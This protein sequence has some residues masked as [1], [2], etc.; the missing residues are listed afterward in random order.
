MNEEEPKDWEIGLLNTYLK[1]IGVK[2]D[3]AYANQLYD[4]ELV[5]WYPHTKK[6]KDYWGREIID[7]HTNLKAAE[8]IIYNG[9]LSDLEE[10]VKLKKQ[11]NTFLAVPDDASNKT[12]EGFIKELI[13]SGFRKEIDTLTFYEELKTGPLFWRAQDLQPSCFERYSKEGYKS[14]ITKSLIKRINEILG[15]NP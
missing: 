5:A 1:S 11:Y 12:L 13:K 3:P 14:P 9:F 8:S 15:K 10:R 7:V 4:S 2:L 6:G